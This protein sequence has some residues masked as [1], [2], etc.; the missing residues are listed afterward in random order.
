MSH[1][2]GLSCTWSSE[3]TEGGAEE[4]AAVR[5]SSLKN[6]SVSSPPAPSLPPLLRLPEPEPAGSSASLTPFSAADA[7][8]DET[9]GLTITAVIVVKQHRQ[10]AQLG[11]APWWSYGRA[12]VWLVSKLHALDAG[13]LHWST[14]LLQCSLLQR[15]G[16]ELKQKGVPLLLVRRRDA[17]QHS[18]HRKNASGTAGSS[19]SAWT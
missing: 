17:L 10:L 19:A 9:T 2:T 14:V 4:P 15:P 5:A 18:S 1:A 16:A 6:T 12:F 11:L 13:V 8:A 7:A 3:M